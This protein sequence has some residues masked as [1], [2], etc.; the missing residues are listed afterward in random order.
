MAGYHNLNTGTCL[1]RKGL[2]GAEY[3]EASAQRL[4]EWQ[5]AHLSV[6]AAPPVTQAGELK[7]ER[8]W[9]R[10]VPDLRGLGKLSRKPTKGRAAKP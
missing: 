4:V 6:E 9:P 8:Y 7:L 10:A 3:L 1:R 5:E 2:S